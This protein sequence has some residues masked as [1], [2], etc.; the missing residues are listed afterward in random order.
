MNPQQRQAHLG[1]HVGSSRLLLKNL[2]FQIYWILAVKT[3]DTMMAD[4]FFFNKP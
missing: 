4:V 3:A 1:L 2:Y